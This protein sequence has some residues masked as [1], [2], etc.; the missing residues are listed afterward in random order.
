MNDIR[1][2]I[3]EHDS[4]RK[5]TFTVTASERWSESMIKRLK[6]RY[7]EDVEITAE[8]KD[9]S[10]VAHIPLAWMRIVPKRQSNLSEEAKNAFAER[11][12]N[13]RNNGS[14]DTY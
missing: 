13:S 9:G 6:Q 4:T 3:Y 12:R 2:T 5:D 10:I 7:P 11:M 1:E 8:N 14:T